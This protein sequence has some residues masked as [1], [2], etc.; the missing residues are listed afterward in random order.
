MDGSFCQTGVSDCV[1][2][3]FIL[4]RQ[5]RQEWGTAT[6]VILC[7]NHADIN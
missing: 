7:V 6:P 4:R 2:V 1:L 3:L 5:L